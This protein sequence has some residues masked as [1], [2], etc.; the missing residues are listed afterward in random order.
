MRNLGWS[1]EEDKFRAATPEGTK[2]FNNIIATHNP[3]ACKRLVLACHYDSLFKSDFVGAT[4][5]AVSCSIM[6]HLA[7]QLT[8]RLNKNQVN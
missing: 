6:V 5:S 1:I 3:K 8:Q 2:P 4:D 7:N